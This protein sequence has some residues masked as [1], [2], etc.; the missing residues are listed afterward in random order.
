MYCKNCGKKLKEGI[1]FCGNCG[2]PVGTG[3]AKPKGSPKKNYGKVLIVVSGLILLLAVCIGVTFYFMGDGYQCKK[4]M[5]QG[6]NYA[7]AGNY[8]EALECYENVLEIDP[9]Y[10]D[11][12]I[13][14]SEAYLREGEVEKAVTIIQRGELLTDAP[15]LKEREE[16]LRKNIVVMCTDNWGM[17][18]VN[19]Y[20]YVQNGNYILVRQITTSEDE[21][22]D[23]WFKREFIYDERGNLS[24]YIVLGTDIYGPDDWEYGE[25]DKDGNIL[26]EIALYIGGEN[27]SKVD[28]ETYAGQIDDMDSMISLWLD[29]GC[30]GSWSEYE[31]DENGNCLTEYDYF[32]DGTVNRRCEYEYKYDENGNC[33]TEHSYSE[34]GTVN[35]RCEYEYD[36][37]GNCLIKYSYGKDGTVN[38]WIEYEY[39]EYGNKLKETFYNQDGDIDYSHSYDIFGFC[40]DDENQKVKYAYIGEWLD[41]SVSE[42]SVQQSSGVLLKYI[43]RIEE[44]LEQEMQ[45]EKQKAS[46]AEDA[47]IHRYEL[48]VSDKTWSEAYNDCVNRGGYL[49]HVNTQEEFD[50]LV[51]QIQEEGKKN[52]IFWLGASRSEDSDY[53]HWID[54]QSGNYQ[55]E[56]IN[57]NPAYDNFWLEGEPS[58]QGTDVNGQVM[59]ERY[60]NMFYRS[61]DERFVWNDAPEDLTVVSDYYKGKI[62][63]ICEYEE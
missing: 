47:G 62:G 33:L 55:E 24:K 17:Q 60:V 32:K 63:Y 12:Y 19:E 21:S 16:Y 43:D 3:F 2:A 27:K 61:A 59:E 35:W 13:Y 25:F 10:I 46:N 22:V 34:D 18:Q 41:G 58:L 14:A 31:Y 36:E 39:D 56:N 29:Y 37:N 4:Y 54:S 44:K 1:A 6:K 45:N 38:S 50:Y 9:G 51:N 8:K 49:A 40:S 23:G 53:Y 20:I 28:W 5:R 57:Q 42:H 52:V 15:E 30:I 26:K 11:A 7:S 48:I